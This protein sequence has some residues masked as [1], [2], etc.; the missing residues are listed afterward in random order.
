M[1]DPRRPVGK[2]LRDDILFLQEAAGNQAV[3]RMIARECGCGGACCAGEG[4]GAG[5]APARDPQSPP[6]GEARP[7]VESLA[8]AAAA[9]QS[10][11]ELQALAGRMD[12]VVGQA[13]TGM[14]TASQP[15]VAT[16]SRLEGR[17]GE[18]AQRGAERTSGQRG[19][20]GAFCQPYEWWE[21]PQA[22]RDKAFL[23]GAL[24]AV[25]TGMFGT[26]EVGAIWLQFVA[27][28]SPSRRSYATP[29]N[30]IVEGFRMAEVTSREHD[31]VLGEIE[32]AVA[33][34]PPA[35]AGGETEVPVSS[36]GIT[37]SRSI[38]WSN[39]YDIPGHLAGGQ[40]GGA[41]GADTRTVQGSVFL[42]QATQADGSTSLVMR[43]D[44]EFVVNDTVDF[45]PGGAGSGLE[46]ALT[47]PLSRLEATGPT[48]AVDVPF[49]VRF[50]PPPV[51]R[52][53][54]AGTTGPGTDAGRSREEIPARAGDRSRGRE[55]GVRREDQP[56]RRVD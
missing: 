20:I 22:A 19:G 51:T 23:I 39:P 11:E 14:A 25:S 2:L 45:C 27:G 3:A 55:D 37:T 10:P 31:T 7:E 18:A 1:P 6:P 21:Y 34:S 29:G 56:T 52:V 28:G 44:V 5:A 15:T 54:G 53:I 42:S 33:A 8:Q 47:V 30:P 43:S 9:S 26:T 35:L 48:W 32:S 38:N 24:P 16:L 17:P 13:E 46:Q 40:S 36:L 49:D 41:G 50:K 12:A 4:N